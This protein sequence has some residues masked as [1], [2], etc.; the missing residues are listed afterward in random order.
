MILPLHFSIGWSFTPDA[1]HGFVDSLP[2]GISPICHCFDEDL[3]TIKPPPEPWVLG[4]WSL[5]GLL[6]LHAV[7]E[8]QLRPQGLILVS[9]TARFCTDHGYDCG[10]VRPS[11]RAMKS[12]LN[13][14]RDSVLSAFYAMASSPH[15]LDRD[16]NERHIR[17]SNQTFS[18]EILLHGLEQLD[19]LD[20]RDKLDDIR[21]P[22]L[23]LHGARDA[24]I[25]HTASQY[26][27]NRLGRATL[28]IHPDA[29]HILPSMQSDW[30]ASQ[31]STFIESIVRPELPTK[32]GQ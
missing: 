32:K 15:P 22:V 20:V 27:A 29:G 9:A 26:L 1:V 10:V 5:G 24:V 28:A 25:P 21:I 2:E 19:K 23:I 13:R 30:L 4:G 3:S 12:G 6:A 7:A 17:L 16:E 11:L 14:D 8:K 31:I 18:T